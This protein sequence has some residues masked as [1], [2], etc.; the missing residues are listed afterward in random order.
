MVARATVTQLRAMALGARRLRVAASAQDA[1]TERVGRMARF[2]AGARQVVVRAVLLGA[3]VVTGW[4]LAV[5]YGMLNVAPAVA[6]TAATTAADT[7]TVT[8]TVAETAVTTGAPQAGTSITDETRAETVT[9]DAF[10]ADAVQALGSTSASDNAEALASAEVSGN[11]GASASAEVSG[12]AGASASAEASGNAGASGNVEAMADADVSGDAEAMA[13][14]T[15]DGLNSQR[16]PGLPPP[17]SASKIL[18]T[19]GLVP[20]GGGAGPFGPASGDVA[21]S[22][23]D[24]RLQAR[25]ALVARVLP[26]V[27]RTAADDPSFSP[28]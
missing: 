28:D 4:L 17:A 8:T 19:N 9:T 13:G 3:L 2:A 1:I 10:Q 22:V 7:V 6:Q 11:A 26:P 23:Y 21:R 24:P 12:N 5:L 14:R 25:R 27:V 18:D 16:D 15:V 20:N